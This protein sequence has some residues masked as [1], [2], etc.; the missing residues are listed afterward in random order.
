MAQEDL[1]FKVGSIKAELPGDLTGSFS[2]IL[3]TRCGEFRDTKEYLMLMADLDIPLVLNAEDERMAEAMKK[4]LGFN[5]FE[6][7]RA[8]YASVIRYV[9]RWWE[10]IGG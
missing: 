2:V 4:R 9:D 1:S 3:R 5:P 6:G 8:D 7:K 10:K